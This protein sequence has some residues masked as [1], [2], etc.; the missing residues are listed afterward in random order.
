MRTLWFVPLILCCTAIAVAHVNDRGMDY[1]RYKDQHGQSC[2][3]D[4]DCRPARDFV[5]TSAN[6]EEVVRL[7][8]DSTWI[9]VPHAYVVS[10]RASDGRAHY[11]GNLHVQAS[12]PA[13]IKLE[14]VC[15]ILPP[16]DT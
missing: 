15:V 10:E 6:G 8:I 13:E 14:P 2:C 1:E 11:C 7:L 5:E 4:R 12:N 16:R 3:N 9:T